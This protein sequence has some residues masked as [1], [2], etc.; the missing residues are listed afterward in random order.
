[1]NNT[2]APYVYDQSPVMIYW[3][4]TQA[5]DLS[6]RHCRAQAIK[7]FDKFELSTQE[8]KVLLL[9]IAQFN[10]KH[11][12]H[13]VMT[14][15]DPLKRDDIYE[16]ISYGIKMGLDISLAPSGTPLLTKE[17]LTKLKDAGVKSI[18]LSLDGSS[19]QIHDAFRMVSGCFDRTINAAK[20][21]FDLNLPFQINTLASKNT[22]ND[23]PKIYN[24][25]SSLNPMTWSIFFLIKTGRGSVLNEIT[26]TEAEKLYEWLYEISKKSNFQIRTTEAPS[27]RRVYLSKIKSDGYSDMSI[28]R[29]FGVRDG[30][31]IMFISRRGQI[32]PSGFLPVSAGNVRNDDIIEIYRNS[33]VF[34]NIRD[35][36]NLEGKCS[37]CEFRY[38]CGGSRARAYAKTQNYME[39][40]PI[41][42]YQPKLNE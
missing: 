8:C 14:G 1:M 10:A 35:L 30:N 27:F 24:L 15:G 36:N 12:P 18:S 19:A 37:Y 42:S 16:L 13:L 6:C 4:V 38:I 28:Q 26:P 41:C 32:F 34:K 21:A 17:A 40:D 25:V 39:S 20:I 23:L 2:S 33:Q 3:E 5:C 29:G 22:L 11:L 31:G 9:Q 7:E